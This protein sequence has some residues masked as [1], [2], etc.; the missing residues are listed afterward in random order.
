M[1]DNL[2]TYIYLIFMVNV[3]EYTSP[4]D[5]TGSDV[6]THAGAAT[7]TTANTKA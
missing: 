7:G 6:T 2:P 3:G 4:M 1:Y 5:P